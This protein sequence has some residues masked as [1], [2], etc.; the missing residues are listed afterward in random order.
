MTILPYHYIFYNQS[1]SVSFLLFDHWAAVG[2]VVI[3][4]EDLIR[5]FI[6]HPWASRVPQTSGKLID[7]Y[8]SVCDS[9]LL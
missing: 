1:V 3:N 2:L 7:I 5:H 6:T 8:I 9:H 4:Q